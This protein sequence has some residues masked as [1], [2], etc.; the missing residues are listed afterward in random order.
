[1]THEERQEQRRRFISVCNLVYMINQRNRFNVIL[2]AYDTTSYIAIYSS[3]DIMTAN[4]LN[5]IQIFH[6]DKESMES[7]ISLLEKYH[8]SNYKPVK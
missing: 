6:N 3:K 4:L 7:A 5:K 1:M 8:G 2:T